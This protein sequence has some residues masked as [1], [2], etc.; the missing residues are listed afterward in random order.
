MSGK[1]NASHYTS[2]INTAINEMDKC[3]QFKGFYITINNSPIHGKNGE[4][5]LLIERRGYKRVYFPSY[6]PKLNLVGQL[7]VAVKREVKRSQ[8]GNTEDLKTTNVE[9]CN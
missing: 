8:F 4:I 5:S 2:F 9:A 7:W 6:S 3:L 1:T